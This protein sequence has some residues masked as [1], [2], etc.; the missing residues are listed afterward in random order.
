M[1]GGLEAALHGAQAIVW[2][3]YWTPV[4]GVHIHKTREAALRSSGWQTTVV[5][6][7]PDVP[8]PLLLCTMFP[9]TC[10]DV[11]AEEADTRGNQATGLL[12]PLWGKRW[13]QALGLQ[14][15]LGRGPG[16]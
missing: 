16:G 11:A 14:A 6:E 15:C 1:A 2:S 7:L 3:S 9:S 12:K 13:P 10:T 5:C 4:R 8:T